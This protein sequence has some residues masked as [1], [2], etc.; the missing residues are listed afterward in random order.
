MFLLILVNKKKG[1]KSTL[2]RIFGK[3]DKGHQGHHQ[4]KGLIPGKSPG[5]SIGSPQVSGPIPNSAS[6]TGG[7]LSAHPLHTS[8]G[9]HNYSECDLPSSDS[10]SMGL[11][12]GMTGSTSAG[13][14]GKFLR[15][16]SNNWK[17]ATNWTF[18]FIVK[19]Q[20]IEKR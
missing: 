13:P 9:M 17:N 20:I 4:I 1:V 15:E 7:F 19:I 2:G 16:N 10:M 12:G 11:A 18:D 8:T 6:L 5:S 14:K 3:K